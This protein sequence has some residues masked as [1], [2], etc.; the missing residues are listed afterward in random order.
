MLWFFWIVFSLQQLGQHR[1]SGVCLLLADTAPLVEIDAA[2]GADALAV[3]GAE[4]LGVHVQDEGRA[5]EIAKV[6]GPVVQEEDA[7]ALLVLQL[8][9]EQVLAPGGLLPEEALQTPVTDAV[10]SSAHRELQNQH[11]RSIAHIAGNHNRLLHGIQAAEV[12]I[13]QVQIEPELHPLSG[14]VD[15]VF[16]VQ[17]HSTPRKDT[18]NIIVGSSPNVKW[19]FAFFRKLL[20][21]NSI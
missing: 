9:G 7:V 10:E 1:Q 21:Y 16:D 14:G 12:H 8:F 2:A 17:K 18:I 19:F 11:P 15:D 5:G 13:G 6:H 20:S 4:G 3:F